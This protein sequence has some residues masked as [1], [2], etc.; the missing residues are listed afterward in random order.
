VL[1]G[2]LPGALGAVS[3][4]YGLAMFDGLMALERLLLNLRPQAKIE[5]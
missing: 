3:V 5:K 1:L 2:L 4:S